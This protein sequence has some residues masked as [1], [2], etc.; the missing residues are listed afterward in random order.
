MEEKKFEELMSE[1]EANVKKLE[2]GEVDLDTSIEI[3]S[4]AMKIAKVCGDKL[5][6]ATESVNK[7][8]MD[9][10]NLVDFKVEE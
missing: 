5:N 10:G 4:E 2:N 7:I 6:K 9:N 3:Y 8:L 1:L